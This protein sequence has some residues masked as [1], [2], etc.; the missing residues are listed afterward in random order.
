[1]T[2]KASI[3]EIDEIVKLVAEKARWLNRASSI[4]KDRVRSYAEL[5]SHVKMS[6]FSQYFPLQK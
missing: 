4:K 6:T 3:A 1:M 2:Q 5:H